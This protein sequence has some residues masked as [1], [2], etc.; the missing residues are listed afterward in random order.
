MSPQSLR[1]TVL[2]LAL[3]A[4][5]LLV[6]CGHGDDGT[7]TENEDEIAEEIDRYLTQAELKPVDQTELEDQAEVEDRADA[8]AG[9]GADEAAA[10][11]GEGG[12]L[13]QIEV[14][15]S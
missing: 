5:P 3:A 15:P 2:A 11:E 1:I 13:Q 8:N 9:K 12:G 10:D 4:M 6:S 14:E 7:P